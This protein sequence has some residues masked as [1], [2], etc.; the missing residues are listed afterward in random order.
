MIPSKK[1]MADHKEEVNWAPLSLLIIAGTLNPEIH[2]WN[3]AEA[4]SVAEIPARGKASGQRVDLS[5][6]VNR[7]V[8]PWEGGRGATRSTWTCENI[9]NRTGIFSGRSWTWRRIFPRWQDRQTRHQ[10]L[11]SLVRPRL[12]NLDDIKSLEALVPVGQRI[13]W[14]VEKKVLVGGELVFWHHRLRN[15]LS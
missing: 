3:K 10:S 8:K 7:Y 13:S 1:Q 5:T 15:R 9:L 12:T 4:H 2:P 11:I 14:N 6:Q